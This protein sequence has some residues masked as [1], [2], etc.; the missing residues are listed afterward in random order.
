M[1]DTQ[2]KTENPVTPAKNE[3]TKA[4]DM[5][6]NLFTSSVVDESGLSKFAA[7]LKDIDIQD[8]LRDA[9]WLSDRLKGIKE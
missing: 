2:I 3:S 5:M 9:Q 4:N 8:V 6:L 1:A 7:G